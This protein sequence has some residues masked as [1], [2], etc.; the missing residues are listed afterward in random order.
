MPCAARPQLSLSLVTNGQSN[1]LYVSVT[2]TS[3]SHISLL[4]SSTAFHKVAVTAFKMVISSDPSTQQHAIVVVCIASSIVSTIFVAIRM[5]T[6][7]FI[8]HSIGW[9]DCKLATYLVF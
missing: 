6:R 1:Q 4:R 2:Q 5:W 8:I 3:I 9:D 7:A